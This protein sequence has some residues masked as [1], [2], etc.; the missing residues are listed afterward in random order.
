MEHKRYFLLLSI[1]F[2]IEFIVI[3][4]NPYNRADWALENVLVVLSVIFVVFTYKKCP[5][6]RLSYS[7]RF[8][9]MSLHEIG[10]Y[11]TYSN[12]PYD[13]FLLSY[14]NVS[15]NEYMG[16]NRNN[17]DRLIHFAYGFLLAYPVRDLYCKI[18]AVK[19]F[20]S[21]FT[22]LNLIMSTS[23]L[24]ELVEW[25]AAEVFG[26]E[27][28]MA[29]LGTQGDIW[30]AHKDMALASL[31]GLLAMVITLLIHSR[32]QKDFREQ[33]RLSLTVNNKGY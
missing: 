6:S 18:A 32:I 10:S 24:Y 22:P 3:S 26:G 16:W 33:W 28:G 15:L 4:I 5:L 8:I 14:F 30:D 23:M 12:V 13:E 29:Y 2:I 9:F 25:G 21:Y 7:L 1:I 27:L 20:W 19:G 11:Y 17:F 31:G